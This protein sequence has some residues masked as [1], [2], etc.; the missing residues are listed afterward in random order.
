MTTLD[1]RIRDL[2]KRGEL[3]HLSLTPTANGWSASYSPASVF[4]NSHAEH[5][6]PVQALIAAFDGI[7]VKRRAP[8]HM[9]PTPE[10][11][12]AYDPAA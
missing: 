2:V 6:D 8:K 9:K 1:E 3:T 10:P 11:D 7:K 12:A 4:G 5:A